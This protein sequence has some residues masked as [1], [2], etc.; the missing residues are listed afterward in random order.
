MLQIEMLKALNLSH[1]QIKPDST[2][3]PAH[4]AP[5]KRS[6]FTLVF[7]IGSSVLT[8]LLLLLSLLK[9]SKFYSPSHSEPYFIALTYH[10]L[11]SYSLS[12]LLG[13]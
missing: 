1:Y 7:I 5:C 6:S 10:F 13:K 12:P 11:V 9:K 4:I 2:R 8:A 3:Y